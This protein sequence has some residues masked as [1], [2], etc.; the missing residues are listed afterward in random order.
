MFFDPLYMMLMVPGLVISLWASWR[1]PSAFKKYSLVRSGRG[2]ERLLNAVAGAVAVSLLGPSEGSAQESRSGFYIGIGVGAAS[3]APLGSSVSAVSTPTK[4]DTLLYDDPSLAPSGAP[5]C[6]DTTPKALSSNGFEPGIGFTG[7]LSAG[8]A[9]KPLRVEFEYRARIHQDDSSPILGSTTNRAVVSKA[10][11]WSPVYP[12]T[13]YVSNYH[14]HQFFANFY[15]D[16]ANDSR[17]T[18]FLGV[19]AGLARTRL[20]YSRRLLRKTIAQGYQ[21][22]DPPLTIA[23]RPARAA[24]TLSL[25]DTPANGTLFGFQVM[26]GVD[27]A[28]GER[29]SI[30]INTRWTHFGDMTND[31][32]WSIIRSHA[33]VRADGVTPFTGELTLDSIRYWAVTVGLK[34]RF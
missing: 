15:Y 22:V 31:V 23:D 18:P 30:E 11:E 5:E 16:F 9:F 34:Y 4:C 17:W 26:G 6:M 19:G 25:L 24:G 8:Y 21:E 33:P 2:I 29:T 1:T 7:I 32:M 20:H 3:A 27:Y 12:P 14:A 28:I 10:T 13:E